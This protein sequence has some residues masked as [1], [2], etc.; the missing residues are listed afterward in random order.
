MTM[1]PENAQNVKEK[2]KEN[3]RMTKVSF[4]SP[5]EEVILEEVFKDPLQYGEEIV[6]N[7][8]KDDC[9]NGELEEHKEEVVKETTNK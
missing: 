2:R 1:I 6:D 5:C 8:D 4:E 3:T 9:V 7:F